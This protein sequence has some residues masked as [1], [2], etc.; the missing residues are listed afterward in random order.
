MRLGGLGGSVTTKA[1]LI[2]AGHTP[3]PGWDDFAQWLEHHH[4]RP[5]TAHRRRP[6][7]AADVHQRNRIPAQ[8]RHAHQPQ[9]DVELHQHHR[10]RRDVARR[11]RDPLT[12]A[13]PLRAVG[14]LPGHRYLSRRDQHHSAAAGTRTV[15]RTI[16]RYGVTNYFAPPTV[17]ISLLRS[18]VFDDVDLSSLRKGY[19]GASAMPIEI[20]A[21]IR[22]R[23][24]NLRL[25]NFYGQTEMAPLA[26][27]L[28]PDEQDAHA[29]SAG[30]PVANVETTILDE[31][32]TP[33]ATGVVGEIAHRSP[34]LMLGYLDDPEKTAE[35]FRGGWF[36]SG[37]LG[38]Y[39]EHG[40][41]TSWTARRT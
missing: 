7:G 21:E 6:A 28:G 4:C 13:L 38:Y 39:D 30:R 25:W 37:D 16:E 18:P 27:A 26:S 20:L 17:W 8:G 35:A 40:C 14:Q 12:A 33:V 11:R 2:P 41:C 32:D 9:P 24:P 3:P 31:D 36:H 22:E 5:A 29:G 1:A 34:H 19:Y 15:L 23:L 10:R